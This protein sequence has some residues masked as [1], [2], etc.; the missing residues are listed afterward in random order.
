MKL[1]EVLDRKGHDVVAC[2]DGVSVREAARTMCRSHVGCITILDLEERIVGILTERDV[3]RHFA[4]EDAGLG[5]RPVSELM[6][7]KVVSMPPSASL[8]AALAMMSERRFRR[9]PVVD[10]DGRLCGLVT[11]GDLVR[12][13]L[14]EKA[15]EAESL[16]EYIAS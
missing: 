5:D 9:L 14:A 2:A 7:R 8:D 15:E 12:A 10:A 16:R 6:S 1:S 11:M 4:S 13:T 3:L